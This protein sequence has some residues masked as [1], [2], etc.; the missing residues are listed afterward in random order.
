LKNSIKHIVIAGSSGGHIL[1]A[2]K[3]LNELSHYCS[4]EQIIF[5]TNEVGAD[6]LQLIEYEKKN[7]IQINSKNK[8]YFIFKILKEIGKILLLNKKVTL[9]GFGGFITVPVLYFAKITNIFFLKGHNINFHEQNYVYG[10]A[11]KFNYFIAHNVFTSFPNNN[12]KSKEIF[13]GN[14][15]AN[16]EKKND[17]LDNK[18]I[19]IL[20][21]GGSA[22]SLE[23]NKFLSNQLLN[24]DRTIIKKLKFYIQVPKNFLE[25]ISSEYENLKIDIDFFTF[26]ENL[27][28]KDFDLIISRSGSGSLHETLYFNNNVYF[29]PHL[30]SRDG[31]QALNLRYFIE[32]SYSLIDFEIPLSKKNSKEYLNSLIN[33][34]SMQKILCYLIR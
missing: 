22:G 13:V 26:N 2:I 9:L 25:E 31:H 19:N 30:H 20:L 29:I 4:S 27:S 1:P 16:L 15:F 5:I 18:F 7:V 10:L 24:I 17:D 33:P 8:V 14:F 6:Y 34:F 23:L 21:I 28:F 12:L 3:Y 32:N 11:N